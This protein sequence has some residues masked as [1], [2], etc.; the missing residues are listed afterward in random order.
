MAKVAFEM[1]ATV[2]DTI[3]YPGRQGSSLWMNRGVIIEDNG[4]S[5]KVRREGKW[6]YWNTEDRVVTL[7]SLGNIVPINVE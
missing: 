4:D 2:G 7:T 5:L 1:E 6:D 3:A